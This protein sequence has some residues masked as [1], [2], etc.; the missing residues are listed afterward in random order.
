MDKSK[1]KTRYILVLITIGVLLIGSLGPSFQ[2]SK[3]KFVKGFDKG[4]QKTEV[5]PLKKTTIVGFEEDS[6]LDDY[7]FLAAIPTSVFRDDEKLFAHPLLFFEDEYKFKDEKERSLNNYQGIKYFMDDWQTFCDDKI[8]QMTL[9]NIEKNKIDSWQAND[10]VIINEENP[11]NLANSIALQDWSYSDDA[12]VAVIDE[13]YDNPNIETKGLISDTLKSMD[14]GHEILE[15]D[16]PA[17][18]PGAVYAPFEIKDNSYKYMV[19]DAQ[20]ADPGYDIDMQI[21]DDEIGMVS[22]NTGTSWKHGEARELGGSYIHNYGTWEIALTAF[23][24]KSIEGKMQS[25][26][27][28]DTITSTGLFSKFKSNKV[29]IDVSLFPGEEIKIEDL[30][31]FG[32]KDAKFTLKWDNPNN[33]LGLTIVDPSGT[34]IASSLSTKDIIN[35]NY[36]NT[37][38]KVEL[39]ISALGECEE[40]QHYRIVVYSLSDINNP[41]DFEV[42]YSWSQK[43][44]RKEGDCLA[45]ATN[46]AVLASSLNAPLLYTSTDSLSE[47]T[48]DVLY[49]LGVENIYLVNFGS[50][51]SSNVKEKLND[52]GSLIQIN[53]HSEIYDKIR[54][55]TKSED[56]VFTTIEPYEYWYVGELLPTDEKE[57]QGSRFIG[58]AALVAAHHGCPV[59]VVDVHPELSQAIIYHK[60]FWIK[61]SPD[62]TEPSAGDMV[63]SGRQVYKFLDE[64]GF[65]KKSEDREESME[66]IITVAG[67]YNIGPSWDRTFVGLATPGRFQF[68]P[69]DTSY[70]ICRN[71][72]YPAII[73]SNPGMYQVTLNQGSSSEIKKIGGRLQKPLGVNLVVTEVG[74]QEFQYP[75]LQTYVSSAYKFNQQAS[76]HWGTYY[77]RADG[78]TP[79]VTLSPDRIDEGSTDKGSAYYPDLDDTNVIPFYCDK[80]GFDSVF[81]TNFEKVAENLNEGVLIWVQDSHGYHPDGGRVSFWDPDSPYVYEENPWRAYEPVMLKL[82]HLRTFIH[83]LLY[84]AGEN[85]GI[86]ALSKLA[87]LKIPIQI[88]SEVGCTKN[89]DVALFNTNLAKAS[90]LVGTVTGGLLEILGAFGF[91]IHWDRLISNPERLPLIT[92]YD[93]MVTTSTRSGAGLIE[94]GITGPDF[95]DALDNIHSAGINTVVCLPAG[96]YLQMTWIRHGAVYTIMD[97]W[98]TSDY[99]AVWLQSIIKNL[100]LGDTIGQA[101]EKGIRACGPEY[102]VEGGDWWDSLE[103]VC[104]YGDPDLRVYVPETQEWDNEVK[105]KWDKPES[106]SYQEDLNLNGHTPYGATEYPH[107]KEP[108][109]KISVWLVIILIIILIIILLGVIIKRKKRK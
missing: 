31:T 66:T 1:N 26:F 82:G 63:L 37:D 6:L 41:I 45:G 50:Y 99:C 68:S 19:A 109:A 20:W 43:F 90:K 21:Y 88:F 14:I 64:H 62:R 100:A 57:E 102:L 65:D 4:P 39:E 71:M 16:R 44:S 10:Y 24:K 91:M 95:D 79:Y 75:V 58:P 49:T 47:A 67:Q 92:T 53:T 73:Y 36:E 69:T 3:L 32:C 74:K 59:L 104:F 94:K 76:N 87:Q 33:M 22:S 7:G 34:E 23:P 29:T 8:D 46:G 81:S 84:F 83:W 80:A 77:T 72:F 98:S 60:D 78:I 42:D 107:E 11:F 70:W 96:T 52:I 108:S 86:S 106:L 15:K 85:L 35:E 13:S 38:N 30:P 55:I 93:G 105:N 97:P 40:D 89:P 17:I 27:E 2:A 61:N 5:I 25:M 51:L 18:G 101:Y 103:N 56:I 9:I 48:K 28:S 54:E 12:V